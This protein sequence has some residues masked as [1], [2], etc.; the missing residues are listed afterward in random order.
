MQ[1][2]CLECEGHGEHHIRRCV[3]YSNECCGGCIDTEICETC[4][5]TGYVDEEE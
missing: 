3:D 4:K 1:V 2:E 5:G